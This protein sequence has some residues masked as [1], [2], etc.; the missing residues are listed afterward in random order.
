MRRSSCSARPRRTRGTPDLVDA[1]DARRR[2][3]VSRSTDA[4]LAALTETV[5]PQ[6]VVAVVPASAHR[7][8]HGRSSRG[9]GWSWCS[10]ASPTRATPA[11]SCAPP[12]RPARRRS[13]SPTAAVDPYNG[14]C[15]RATAG[16]LFHLS[17]WSAAV[18][19]RPPSAALRQAG[20]RVLAADAH[21]ADDL[22]EL[23]RVR[24]LA[25]RTAWLFGSEAHGLPAELA[26][27]GRR[28]GTGADPWPRREP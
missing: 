6:G 24:A 7:P 11:P 21:G 25:A 23:R 1:A 26:A 4:G 20:L 10:P 5:T 22:D 27:A 9:H 15:V 19:P 16:S 13:C 28:P 12:T 8:G 2:A 3:G 14:K 18:R 17:T